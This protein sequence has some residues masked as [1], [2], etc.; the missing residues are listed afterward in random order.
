MHPIPSFLAGA[1]AATALMLGFG[2]EVGRQFDGPPQPSR[3]DTHLAEQWKRERD[4]RWEAEADLLHALA[5]ECQLRGRLVEMDAARRQG[6][7]DEDR[8]P[9]QDVPTGR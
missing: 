5:R 2:R 8:I 1:L 3:M 6:V 9:P 7:A 4:R